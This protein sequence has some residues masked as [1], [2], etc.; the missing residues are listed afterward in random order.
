VS[1][2]DVEIAA[3]EVGSSAPAVENAVYLCCLESIQN[4]VKHAGREASVTVR[5]RH[6]A[7]ELSFSVEDD[8]CGFDPRT[9]APGAGL[10]GVRERIETA[11]GRVEIVAAPGRGTTVAGAVPW[12]ARQ[13]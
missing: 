12:P 3:G 9:T 10:S 1:G 8:G 13:P 7:D 2:I 11:G 5:L 4:A 6:E